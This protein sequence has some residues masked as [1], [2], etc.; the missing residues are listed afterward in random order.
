M[1]HS[2]TRKMIGWLAVVGGLCVF[3]G[4]VVAPLVNPSISG[5]E[6]VF[7]G[8]GTLPLSFILIDSLQSF[9]AEAARKREHEKW[10]QAYLRA[11]QADAEHTS[12]TE[13]PGLTTRSS[14][15]AGR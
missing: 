8:L 6:R 1:L 11:D 4:L 2:P 5:W 7:V 15:Q 3:A 9:V 14:E 13:P 10:L 12:S